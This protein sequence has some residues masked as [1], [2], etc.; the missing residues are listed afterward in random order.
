MLG[1]LTENFE[2]MLLLYKDNQSARKLCV[3]LA[4]RK[5]AKDIDIRHHY[6]IEVVY[7]NFINIKYLQ[8]SN[9]PADIFTKS[10]TSVKHNIFLRQ[11][12]LIDVGLKYFFDLVGVLVINQH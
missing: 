6:V 10:L 8:S 11:L 7:K 3:N 12:G 9:I 4:L 2:C 1:E 5:R